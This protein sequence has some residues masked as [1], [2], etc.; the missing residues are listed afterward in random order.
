MEEHRSIQIVSVNVS[1]KKGTVK[2]PVTEAML[3]ETGISEDAHS[4]SWHRQVSLLSVETI[5]DFSARFGRTVNPGEFAENITTKGID[6][7]DV[8]LLDRFVIGDAELEVSQI[9]K[10]CHGE[11]CAIFREVGACVMPGEGIFCR[12]IRGGRIK[13]GD[14]VRYLPQKLRFMVITLSDRAS[15]GLIS[16][17]SGPEIQDMLERSFSQSRWR[18]EYERRILPD[19]ALVLK[20]AVEQACSEH[21]DFIF[22][23]GGTGIGPR[24]ITPE[25]LE[26]MFDR[27]LPGLMEHIRLKYGADN[28]KALLS[29][30]TAGMIGGTL[31]YALP[32]SVRAVREYMEEILKTIEHSIYMLHGIDIHDNP[33]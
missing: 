26:P 2:I 14:A 19:D 24:D 33:L 20:S 13:P 17:R 11:T 22:T 28:P 27:K 31:V 10:T 25:T 5:G 8:A 32:G 7:R 1:E 23:T 15:G 9:G 30:S 3:S 12:V 18:T 6:L 16:D 29:R 4:G 21:I